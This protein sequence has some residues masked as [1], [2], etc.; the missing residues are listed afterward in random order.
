[1]D[2]QLFND[3]RRAAEQLELLKLTMGRISTEKAT[4]MKFEG[5][6][7]LVSRGAGVETHNANVSMNEAGEFSARPSCRRSAFA[8][9]GTIKSGFPTCKRCAKTA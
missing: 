1:M 9:A 2:A 4:G 6:V 8:G 7:V 3:R 5:F